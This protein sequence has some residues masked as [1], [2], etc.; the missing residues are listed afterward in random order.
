MWYEASWAMADAEAAAEELARMIEQRALRP[1]KIR[2]RGVPHGQ[3]R[4][5]CSL[6]EPQRGRC[7][8]RRPLKIVD[9]PQGPLRVIT[10]DPMQG[11]P[12]RL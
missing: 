8:D 1:P 9:G 11:R 10:L 7:G 5:V 3:T 6:D 12:G 4:E 2:A